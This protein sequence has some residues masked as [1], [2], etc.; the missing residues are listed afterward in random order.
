MAKKVTKVDNKVTVVNL[1]RA[2]KPALNP[3]KANKVGVV[4][5]V[6]ARAAKAASRAA[7]ANK[8]KV[9]VPVWAA[10]AIKAAVA[11]AN[12]K[13]I[14]P[15]NEPGRIVHYIFLNAPL[16]PFPEIPLP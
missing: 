13:A 12:C 8:D 10:R 16:L 15:V 5:L 14:R 7:R 6:S 1:G 11:I 9:V 2:S 4:V 3:D